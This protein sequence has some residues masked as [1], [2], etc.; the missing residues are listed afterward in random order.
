MPLLS[1]QLVAGVAGHLVNRVLDTTDVL[2]AATIV[3][4][5]LAIF[6]PRPG[7]EYGANLMSRTALFRVSRAVLITVINGWEALTMQGSIGGLLHGRVGVHWVN[8]R[9]GE[10]SHRCTCTDQAAT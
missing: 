3:F 2:R 4:E 1:L 6:L 5:P 8:R 7:A 9:H 10:G